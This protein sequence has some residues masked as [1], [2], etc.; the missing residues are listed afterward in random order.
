MNEKSTIK[1][2]KD[3]IYKEHKVDPSVQV[4]SLEPKGRE[5][6]AD[7]DTMK[8]LKLKHG[9]VLYLEYEGEILTQTTGRKVNP[10]GSLTAAVVDDRLEKTAF[11]PGLKSLR[12]MKMH[13][14]LGEFM[15]MNSQFEYKIQRQKNPH[16]KG[17]S[18]DTAS[19]N[20][21]QSYLRQFA[22]QQSRCGWLYGRI[23]EDN[24]IFAECIYEPPQS[25]NP[26]GFEVF[27]DPHGE[28]ADAI[29]T[30]LG[31][32]KI[33]WVFSHPPREDSSF[34]FSSR[35]ILLAAQLQVD[36]GGKES[37]FVTL[38]VTLDKEGQASFE[39]FQVSDQCL[40]MFSAGAIIENPEKPET[41]AI[42]D[43]FSAI[44]EAKEA[45]EV[46]NNFFLCVVPVLQHDSFLKV[47]FPKS[48][49][50]GSVRTREKLSQQLDKFKSEPYKNR[51]ADFELLLF[52]SDFLDPSTDIPII[53]QSIVN[54]QVP[55]DTGYQVL[56]DSVSGRQ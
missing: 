56:I 43:T 40:D 37:P 21:F 9:D 50:E 52:L 26:H 25:G 19:C 20:S 16:C 54:P 38:K 39:A 11:R 8:R 41:C 36:S 7:N 12:D 30:A 1:D 33:G 28:K 14:T 48:N 2:V 49:R 6:V 34:L 55:L 46:D 24:N 44:V 3:F 53:C 13:W 17:I 4:L 29:A 45:R 22:F 18:I 5:V 32:E 51:I 42:Q 47:S 31:L 23:D 15:E 27:D 10:D 35:E